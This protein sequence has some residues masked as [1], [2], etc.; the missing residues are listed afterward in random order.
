MTLDITIFDTKFL[1]AA[2]KSKSYQENVLRR[3]KVLV[4]FLQEHQLTHLRLLKHGEIPNGDFVIKKSDLTEEG[5]ELIKRGLDKWSKAYVSG[6]SIEDTT[7]L[8]KELAK[9]RA[10]ADS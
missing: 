9:I 1:L 5:F 8:E 10:K 6:A 2:S 3:A 7:I 4:N